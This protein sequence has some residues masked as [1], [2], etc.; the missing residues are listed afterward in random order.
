MR[1][2]P[3]RRRGPLWFGARLRL[4]LGLGAAVAAAALLCG[5]P[6]WREEPL[7]AAVA[8]PAC[9]AFATAGNLLTA[10]PR[11]RR[12]GRLFVLAA[13]A[14]AITWSAAWNTGPLPL[15]SVFAQSACYL[16]I[17]T[18]VLLYP[19]GR[20]ERPAERLWTAAAALVLFGGQLALCA[21]SR[22]QWNGFAPSAVWPSPLADRDLFDLLLRWL[23]VALVAL[24]G[25][26]LVILALRVPRGGR[27]ERRLTVPVAAAMTVAA[28]AGA[29]GQGALAGTDVRLADVLHVYLIQGSSAVALPLAFLAGGLRERLDELT[30]A[31]RMLRLTAPVSVERVRDALREV[32]RDDTLDLWF[33]VPEEEIH[34]D[35]AGRAVD[36]DAGPPGSSG[37]RRHEVRTEGGDRLAVV[38][39]GAALA[40]HAPLLE[41]ALVAGA[42][43]LETAQLQA[44]AQAHLE[45]ARAA[46]ERL[47]RV[48]TAERERL[49][50]DLR[51]SAQRRLREL[52]AMLDDLQAADESFVRE[53]ARA[54]RRELAEAITEIGHL[55]QG[56][57]PTA[58]T[59]GGL[60][61]ALEQVAGRIRLPVHLDLPGR[62]FPPEVE[63]TLYFALCEALAN[64]VKHA[65]A[66]GV[67]LTVRAVPGRV[68]AEVRDDGAGGARPARGRGG[69]SGVIDRVRALRGE[70]VVDSPPGEGTTV[71]ISVPCDAH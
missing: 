53:Q 36:L 32:L 14:W 33:W 27:L 8:P 70:V 3:R 57:H 12:T 7:A 25:S 24:V 42:R 54:C 51:H 16:A 11:G 61:P 29:A 59:G 31:E 4:A 68:V 17:G 71:R 35:V 22:P 37:R 2:V 45:R 50:G 9:G 60:G 56:V 6:Y 65:G 26:L 18:G 15:V 63:S 1:A 21:A 5:W 40:G 43:A 67:R 41:A 47:V 62:R 44:T 52:A 19:S 34:V 64:T 58:L 23:V 48:Q 28:V 30:V 69:L 49:A 38:E 10:G 39:V 66:T 46:Q 20:L 55:A 13:V